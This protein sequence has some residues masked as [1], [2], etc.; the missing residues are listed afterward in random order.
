[1]FKSLLCSLPCDSR[2]IPYLPQKFNWKSH[3]VC[4]GRLLWLGGSCGKRLKQLSLSKKL[5]VDLTLER[6]SHLES[7][8]IQVLV[9]VHVFLQGFSVTPLVQGCKRNLWLHCCPKRGCTVA[10]FMYYWM[11]CGRYSLLTNLWGVFMFFYCKYS[12]HIGTSSLTPHGGKSGRW[13]R[14]CNWGNNPWVKLTSSF[15]F[16]VS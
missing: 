14:S 10:T 1:M 16:S 8:F 6:S 3:L 4:V 2:M 15:F 5:Q 12:C 11:D 7:G 9:V 13:Y